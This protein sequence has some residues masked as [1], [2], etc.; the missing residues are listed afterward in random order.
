MSLSR[1]ILALLLCFAVSLAGCSTLETDAPADGHYH[2]QSPSSDGIGKLYYGREISD[3]MG[4]RGAAWLERPSRELDERPDAAAAA[5]DLRPTDTVADIGAGSG[6]IS[7]LLAPYVPQGKILAVDIQPEMLAR[8]EAARDQR[9]IENVETV[10]GTPDDPHLPADSVDL[11]VMV[12]AYHEFAYPREMMAGIVHALKPGGRVVLAEYRAEN[13]LI[14]IKRHHKM[15][16][17]QVKR[18]LTAAGLVWEKTDE[19]LPQQHL[20]FFRKPG[21]G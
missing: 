7:F 8:L 16:E 14:L 2:T 9:Q 3:V 20:V 11:A 19:R 5:L 6:Y 13:P 18:E 10:L 17:Q 21:G 12:D 1:P 15:S 4:H